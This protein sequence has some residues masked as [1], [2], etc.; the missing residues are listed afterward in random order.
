MLV[1]GYQKWYVTLEENY[2][3]FIFSQKICDKIVWISHII[4]ILHTV[5]LLWEPHWAVFSCL[6]AGSILRRNLPF[7]FLKSETLGKIYLQPTEEGVRKTLLNG[8][9]RFEAGIKSTLVS[10]SHKGMDVSNSFFLDDHALCFLTTADSSLWKFL[11]D[12]LF[13]AKTT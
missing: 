3:S 13:K 7:F 4:S 9:H 12:Q 1:F 6:K 11:F 10:L 5:F 2:L 8:R